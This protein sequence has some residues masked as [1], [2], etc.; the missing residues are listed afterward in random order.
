MK[1]PRYLDIVRV[2]EYYKLMIVY[3]PKETPNTVRR[4]EYNQTVEGFI[5]DC[6]AKTNRIKEPEK[7]KEFIERELEQ[8]LG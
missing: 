6:I 4:I 2:E 5:K 8:M 1:E 3:I 7:R